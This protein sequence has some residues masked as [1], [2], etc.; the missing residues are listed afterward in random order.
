MKQYLKE[1]NGK[2]LYRA[3]WEPNKPLRIGDI[4]ILEKGVFSHRS[5]LESENIPMKVRVDESKGSLKYNSEGSVEIK[6]KLS[7]KAKMPQSQLGELDAGFTINFSREK[8]IVFQLND[9]KTHIITNV[10]AIETEVLNR[11]MQNKWRKNWVIITELIEGKEGTIIISNSKE[12]SIELKANANVNPS[13]NINIAD[14]NLDLG[15]VSKKNIGTEIIAKDGLTPLYRV[16]GIKKKIFGGA[17]GLEAKG[18]LDIGTLQELPL[19]DSEF[20]GEE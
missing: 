20:E 16:A 5:T 13:E 8:S 3:T 10:G 15:V 7:G 12:S 4:G 11:F 14:A 9:T 6:T 2:F 19:E 17:S 1:M 18:G